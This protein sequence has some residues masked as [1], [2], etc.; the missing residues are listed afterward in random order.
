MQLFQPSRRPG[1]GEDRLNASERRTVMRRALRFSLIFVLVMAAPAS[2]R[3]AATAKSSQ[4]KPSAAPV[5]L[6][7]ASQAELEALPGVGPATA[8]KI[9][10]GRPYAAVAD[11][12]K[13]GVAKNTI[14]KI[15]PMVTVGA[16]A[17]APAKPGATAA[18]PPAPAHDARPTH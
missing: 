3:Q 17:A 2:A 14:E 8:K 18:P 13:A 12:A 5:N 1:D 6:N 7:T 16:P 11:L 10:A 15:T 9:I 4:A